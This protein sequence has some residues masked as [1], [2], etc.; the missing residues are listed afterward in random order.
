MND[1]GPAGGI[2]DE[3]NVLRGQLGVLDGEG[4][5]LELWDKHI[6]A[7][8]NLE[9]GLSRNSNPQA[10]ALAR[11]SFERLL[12][13]SPLFFGYWKK[14]A[15][16]EF[17]I[18]GTESAEMVYERGIAANPH[19][20]DLW[21]EYCRFKMDTCHNLDVVREHFERASVAVGIDFMSHPFWDKYIEFET[22][23]EAHSRVFAI[24]SRVCRIP[25]HQYSRYYEKL[26]TMAHSMPLTDIATPEELARCQAEVQAESA[27]QGVT[28][29]PELEVERDVRTKID[30]MY[31][32]IFTTTANEVNNRWTYESELGHQY[33]HTVPLSHAQL[34]GWRKYLDFEEAGGD[35]ERIKFLYERCVNTCALYDEFWYRFARWMSSHAGKGEEVRHIYI[36]A[37]FLVPVSRPGIRLQWAYFEESNGRIDVARDIHAGI[38]FKLPDCTEVIISWA[39]LERRQGG[40]E[41]AIQVLRDHIDAP[42]VNLYTKAMLVA[43][44]A[45]L[46]WKAKGSAEAARA[47]FAKNA[48]WYGDSRLFWEKWFEFE[49]EQ[50][51]ESEGEETIGQRVKHVYDE[52]RS[53]SRLSA[54]VKR[55]LGK[56]Y[57]DFLVHRGGKDAMKEFLEVDRAIFGSATVAAL[58]TNNQNGDAGELDED[59]KKKAETRLFFF[60]DHEEQ[61][62]AATGPAQF[63]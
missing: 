47:V 14:Y 28:S 11:D 52:F 46:L 17:V 2:D 27:A 9:G 21:A 5:N 44:W 51:M 37:A 57:L 45:K 20:V 53:K 12:S 58:S 24:L 48:Q 36:Q 10:L 35:Y 7:V 63:E 43:E 26:R 40:T 29:R 23:Q 59:S 15:E 19:S 34:N 50:P 56:I 55:D 54:A 16:D 42:T 22:R 39:H 31:Y 3:I 6:N 32:E 4:D 8:E 60:Y 61:D 62:P 13:R 38:L 25:L 30:A 1:Y 41:A 33:F 18:S 49:L